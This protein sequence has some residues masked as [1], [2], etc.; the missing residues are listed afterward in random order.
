[1][2]TALLALDACGSSCPRSGL[3]HGLRRGLSIAGSPAYGIVRRLKSYY[4]SVL[5]RARNARPSHR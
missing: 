3:A 2:R 5:S 1:M 4:H